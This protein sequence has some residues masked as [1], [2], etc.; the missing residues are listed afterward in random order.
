MNQ[1]WKERIEQRLDA[2]EKAQQKSKSSDDIDINDATVATGEA[3]T[4]SSLL[5][6]SGNPYTNAATETLRNVESSTLN[7]ASNL[8]M[9]PAASVES[10]T[11]KDVASPALDIISR[12]IIPFDVAEEYLAYFHSHLDRFLHS[13]LSER[14][15]IADIRTRSSLLTTAICTVVSLCTASDLHRV[16]YDAL[17]SEVSTKLFALNNGYDD[18]RA[19]CV[20]ALWID[21][22]AP[23]LSGLGKAITMTMTPFATT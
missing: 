9:F 16:C 2:L 1:R 22:I 5:P 7:L 11:P 17:V 13:I 6:T 10:R 18:V 3:S 15:T 14:D 8:G 23:T 19:L 21:D 4:S 20:A 12:G